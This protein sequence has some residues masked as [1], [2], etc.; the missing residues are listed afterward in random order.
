MSDHLKRLLS[1][2]VCLL[3]LVLAAAGCQETPPGAD[4]SLS[5]LNSSDEKDGSSPDFST[6]KKS[7]SRLAKL[8][9]PAGW[10]CTTPYFRKGSKPGTASMKPSKR[11]PISVCGT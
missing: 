6:P 8:Y 7:C 11:I 10:S 2:M 9:G 5:H 4:A 1:G 3:M